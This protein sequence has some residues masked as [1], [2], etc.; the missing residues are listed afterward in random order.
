MASTTQAGSDLSSRSTEFITATLVSEENNSSSDSDSTDS[1][2][3]RE[4]EED[5]QRLRALFLKA[6]ASA[7][8]ADLAKTAIDPL[9][10]NDQLVLFDE[11]A[12]EASDSDQCVTLI[13]VCKFQRLTRCIGRTI[14]PSSSKSRMKP[15]LPASLVRPLHLRAPSSTT[16][17]SKSNA[18]GKGKETTRI[19]LAQDLGGAIESLDGGKGSEDRWGRAPQPSLSK[20]QRQAVSFFFPSI[21]QFALVIAI[22]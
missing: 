10:N 2:E 11:E 15:S 12:D 19:T 8:A 17:S 14:T 6:K 16:L 3:E 22:C 21:S 18:K 13:L 1:D 4:Q 7:K 20:K 5:R 9:K